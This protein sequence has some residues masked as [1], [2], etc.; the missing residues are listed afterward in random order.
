MS[1]ANSSW[2]SEEFKSI[3]LSDPRLNKRFV[4]LAEDLADNPG[5]SIHSAA[6]DWAATKGAYRFFDNPEV[7]AKKILEPHFESTCWRSTSH[8][9]V[10][11]A[12]DT[13]YIDFSQHKKTKGLGTSFKSHG[14]EVKGICCHAGLAM[15]ET[16]LPLGL[17]FN[18]LW[19]RKENQLEGY[20]RSAVPFP[21]KESFRWVETMRAAKKLL[22]DKEI[23][24]LAD[25]EGDIY[26]VFEEA[27]NLEMDVVVR[28][29]HDRVIDEEVK[30]S[31][32]ISTSPIRGT[33][34]VLIPS[35]GS[36]KERKAKL[37]IRF[38]RVILKGRPNDVK[39]QLNKMREDVELYLVDA[40]EVDG[41]LHWRILTTIPVNN[42]QGAKDI[43]NYYKMRWNIETYFKTL[44]TGCGIEKCR[45][46]EG[47]RL[48]KYIGLMSVL[49]WRLFWMTYVSRQNPNLP[50]ENLLTESEWKT[51]WL[52]LNRRKIKEG[53]ILK[54]DWPKSPPT[55]R[56]AIR[57]IAGNGGFLGRKGDGEPGIITFWRGWTKVLSGVEIY[58]IIR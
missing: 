54:K 22:P 4:Q 39:T 27:F 16:G 13:S 6:A 57:W 35:S 15:S 34:T 42:L 43:L 10:V 44:K 24:Y 7:E 2:I 41:D 53:K 3:N 50:C 45:L 8:K 38:T 12:A 56:E 9:K 21:L 37:E 52:M 36:R 29:Q 25:R 47:S 46:G 5:K 51:A 23:I 28:S 58:E 32:E 31:E 49:A 26:E 11:L 48:V 1:R 55:L 18:K 14:Q 40:A 17:L 19:I 30:L 33:H 20:K